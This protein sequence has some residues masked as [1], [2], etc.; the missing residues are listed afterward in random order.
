GAQPD[1]GP[2]QITMRLAAPGAA[3]SVALAAIGITNELTATLLLPA[4]KLMR[5]PDQHAA[6]E[7]DHIEQL[8]YALFA[9]ENISKRYGP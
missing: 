6:V 2:R 7:L 5:A 3:A 4:G 9:I 1:H 8:K